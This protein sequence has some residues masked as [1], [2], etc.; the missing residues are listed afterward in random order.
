MSRRTVAVLGLGPSGAYAVRAAL[1]AG[2]DVHV[3]AANR[4]L[5][6]TPG[7]FWLHWVP[8]SLEFKASKYPILI[9]CIGT[10]DVYRRKQWGPDLAKLTDSSFK[11]GQ[12]LEYGY[13]PLDIFPYLVKYG[14]FTFHGL[15]SPLQQETI[16][17]ISE[18]YDL[19]FQTFPAEASKKGQPQLI[20]YI[21]AAISA[22]DER[23]NWVQYN[24]SDRG[25]EVRTAALF[26]KK[27]LEF[28]K[29]MGLD[30][31]REEFNLGGYQIVTLKDISPAAGVWPSPLRNIHYIGRFAEWNRKRLSH[32]VYSIVYGIVS[33]HTMTA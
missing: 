33:K 31:I 10:E 27:Y 19:V 16:D 3:F 4:E 11:Q 8:P 14:E 2:S 12:F 30:A 29:G 24:G 6:L 22:A 23:K 25:L 26:G 1:D 32:E 15:T 7:A 17:W 18:D 5:E 13:N 20:P 21:M 9:N 28:P